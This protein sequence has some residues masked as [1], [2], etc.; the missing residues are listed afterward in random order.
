MSMNR[1]AFTTGFVCVCASLRTHARVCVCVLQGH[2]SITSF[3]SSS[4]H[5]SSSNK[6]EWK[7][8][9]LD[10]FRARKVEQR[11]ETGYNAKVRS[12]HLWGKLFDYIANMS[13][14]PLP[15]MF[16]I[17]FI[18]ESTLGDSK[19]DAAMAA[20]PVTEI[21]SVDGTR[22]A[23]GKVRFSSGGQQSKNLLCAMNKYGKF[24]H[25]AAAPSM[26]TLHLALVC[27]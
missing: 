20:E 17:D 19:F 7:A 13:T 12:Y 26:C 21:L 11:I 15:F 25:F 6:V 5:P 27:F 16:C 9:D 14:Q 10:S 2:R 1:Y 22:K 23:I 18:I 4:S 8:I 3:F 24:L